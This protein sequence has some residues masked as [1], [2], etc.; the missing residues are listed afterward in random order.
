MPY[1]DAE[2]AREVKRLSA[3]RRRAKATEEQR[4]VERKANAEQMERKRRLEG[5]EPET[6][7]DSWGFVIGDQTGVTHDVAS[8]E[9][10]ASGP[11]YLDGRGR[12]N[13]DRA[14][15][16]DAL[17][18]SGFPSYWNGACPYEGDERRWVFYCLRL[19]WYRRILEPKLPGEGDE[20]LSVISER[21]QRAAEARGVEI[22]NTLYSESLDVRRVAQWLRD[23]RGDV[24][25][26]ARTH[27]TPE[28][29]QA[30]L[31]R[32]NAIGLYRPTGIQK[33]GGGWQFRIQ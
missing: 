18:P 31:E 23:G 16:W 8:Y 22:W 21:R 3:Q 17:L 24:P 11:E 14:W 27:L 33:P 15:Y 26:R 13:L 20:L 2:K 25:V 32:L 9:Y 6:R 29:V 1:K 10:G 7:T 12:W 28:R 4:E 5:H 19:K 30:A